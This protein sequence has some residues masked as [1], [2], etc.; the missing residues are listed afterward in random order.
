[1]PYRRVEMDSSTISGSSA[2]VQKIIVLE[3]PLSESFSNIVKLDSRKGLMGSFFLSAR[4]HRPNVDKLWLIVLASSAFRFVAPLLPIRSDPARSTKRN[5]D[6]TTELP[7]VLMQFSWTMQWER[8]DLW[9]IWWPLQDR[10]ISTSSI[11]LITSYGE[12]KSISF[13][14]WTSKLCF[15]VLDVKEGGTHLPLASNSA[16]RPPTAALPLNVDF[17]PTPAIGIRTLLLSRSLQSL[18]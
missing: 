3:F 14:P 12:F 4:M 1:M 13:W 2:I 18:K 5:L 11:T 8:L 15:P 10:V 16:A 9:L 7:F 6:F 17:V